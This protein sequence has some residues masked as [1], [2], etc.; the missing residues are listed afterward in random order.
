MSQNLKQSVPLF[1]QEP[2]GKLDAYLNELIQKDLAALKCA[3]DMEG[4]RTLQGRI[5]AYETVRN[6]PDTVKSL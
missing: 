6:L 3:N 5:Q 2:W 1:Y 4:V